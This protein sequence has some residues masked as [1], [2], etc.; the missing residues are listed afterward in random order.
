MLGKNSIQELHGVNVV[1]NYGMIL[2]LLKE[3]EV[4]T[5]QELLKEKELRRYHTQ[6]LSQGLIQKR[7]ESRQDSQKLFQGLIQEKV[8]NWKK[9]LT[10]L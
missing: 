9:R 8:E 2:N 5:Q 4:S 10:F 1:E 7:V 3:R 6:R